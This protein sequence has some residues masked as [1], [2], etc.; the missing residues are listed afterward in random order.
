MVKCNTQHDSPYSHSS[1]HFFL[2]NNVLQP[3]EILPFK[4]CQHKERV[5]LILLWFL[6]GPFWVRYPQG[7]FAT[8]VLFKAFYWSRVQPTKRPDK[9]YEL[10]LYLWS[11]WNRS[12][13][14]T[15]TSINKSATETPARCKQRILEVRNCQWKRTACI[16]PSG[17]T[18]DIYSLEA[19]C[20]IMHGGDSDRQFEHDQTRKNFSIPFLSTTEGVESSVKEPVYTFWYKW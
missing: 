7:C 15:E 14:R 8:H 16:C 1:Y 12:K 11:I 20:K 13:T 5:L 4:P 18:M 9:I 2:V 6:D 10:H 17:Q 19:I 3:L